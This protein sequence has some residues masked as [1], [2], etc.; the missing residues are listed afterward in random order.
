MTEFGKT[1]LLPLADLQALGYRIVIYPQTALRVA[2]GAIDGMLQ[3][4]KGAGDQSAWIDR[5]QT[6]QQL[7]DLLDYDGLARIDRAATTDSE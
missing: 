2:F 6:R 3:D 4:L 5:M 1:P 7:Y